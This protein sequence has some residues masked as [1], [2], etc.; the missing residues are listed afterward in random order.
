MQWPCLRVL[1]KPNLLNHKPLKITQ[2]TVVRTSHRLKLLLVISGKSFV[3]IIY[4]HDFQLPTEY[5][6]CSY[7]VCSR[8]CLTNIWIAHVSSSIS[9]KQ[10]KLDLMGTSTLQCSPCLVNGSHL[11]L[12]SASPA[13]F[14]PPTCSSKDRR[15]VPT[16]HQQQLD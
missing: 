6:H 3:T 8:Q 10:W 11:I 12:L 9:S 15:I 7:T 4:N 2:S 5:D 14:L 16:I 13:A 1:T